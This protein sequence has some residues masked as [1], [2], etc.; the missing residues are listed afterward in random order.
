MDPVSNLKEQRKLAK[1]LLNPEPTESGF[2]DTM[3]RIEQ[4]CRL[5]ELVIEL[6]EWR[7]A[8]GFDPY[9]SK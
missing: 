4:A 9:A 5:A 3:K 7:L 2:V 6:D 8:G 1:A